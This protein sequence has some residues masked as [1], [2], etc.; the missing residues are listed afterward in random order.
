MSEASRRWDDDR[1]DRWPSFGLPRAGAPAGPPLT[2]PVDAHD[3]VRGSASALVTLVEYADF[4][5][6][7]CGRALP[8][9]NALLKEY[10][11]TLRVVF[12][13]FPLEWEHPNAWLA[14]LASEAAARQGR[15]W[16]M[17]DELYR[18]Q[19]M[20]HRDALPAH[21]A[22]VGLDLVQFSADLDD[23][24]LTER[25]QRDVDSG[26]LNHVRGTPTVFIDGVRQSA[27]LIADALRITI[28]EA[29][30]HRTERM[31]RDDDNKLNG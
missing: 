15:F 18:N 13:H 26:R 2:D 11:G 27:P 4:E 12:R 29:A 24:T 9:I 10:S 23:P 6:L 31:L 25:V 8:S 14:A 20:L 3:H 16:E 5:C 7:H 30:M 21:A 19:L 22:S 28:A 17:H 1:S